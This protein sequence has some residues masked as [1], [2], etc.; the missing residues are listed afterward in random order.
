MLLEHF[1]RAGVFFFFL[2]LSK[3]PI[4]HCDTPPPRIQDNEKSWNNTQFGESFQ[5]KKEVPDSKLYQV[6]Y[7]FCGAYIKL[8]QFY[9]LIQ[10]NTCW[11]STPSYH[12][13][14]YSSTKRSY[15]HSGPSNSNCSNASCASPF[16]IF[17]T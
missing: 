9:S 6:W 8:I 5:H 17:R 2:F 15:C 11:C 14:R 4:R 16:F 3:L 12:S 1:R 13:P 7:L 10:C